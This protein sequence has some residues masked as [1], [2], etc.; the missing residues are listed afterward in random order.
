MAT[1]Y[2]ALCKEQSQEMTSLEAETLQYLEKNQW[3]PVWYLNE[4]DYYEETMAQLE[5]QK[6]LK[7][8]KKTKAK[9][10]WMFL[11]N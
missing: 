4:Q 9:V 6:N 3:P 7:K 5:R 10:Q 11:K 8:K 1:N 2:N